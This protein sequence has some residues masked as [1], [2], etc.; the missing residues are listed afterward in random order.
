MK[1]RLV[2]LLFLFLLGFL[3]SCLILTR[4][5]NRCI[6]FWTNAS[7]LS[8][9]ITFGIGLVARL[10]NLNL[11]AILAILEKLLGLPE[12]LPSGA[13]VQ[14]GIKIPYSILVACLLLTSLF[15]AAQSHFKWLVPLE[16][17]PI[18]E[19]FGIRSVDNTLTQDLRPGEMINIPSHAQILIEPKIS[20]EYMACQWEKSVG[21]LTPAGNEKCSVLYSQPITTGKDS[22]ILTVSSACGTVQTS[23]GFFVVP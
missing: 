13:G 3:V 9:P 20:G 18:I 16:N 6:D 1:N 15:Y 5:E 22:L 14:Q 11:G 8:L 2:V 17:A 10:L 7:L 19:S 23:A 4:F 12:K 21:S